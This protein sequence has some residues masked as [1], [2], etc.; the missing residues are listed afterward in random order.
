MET[1]L[2]NGVTKVF[3]VIQNNS[4]A[5]AAGVVGGAAVLGVGAAAVVGAVKRRKSKRR[6]ARNVRKRSRSSRARK[7]RRK[8][9]RTAGK[10]KD[11]SSKRIR[12][13]KNG[14]P[15]IILRSGKARFIKQSSAKRSHKL[16]GGRY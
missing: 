1:S 4:V 10:G 13:T 6:K 16:K 12:Y 3:G 15:Y 5:T 8:T 11:K 14:Q 7:R 9:P 2:T